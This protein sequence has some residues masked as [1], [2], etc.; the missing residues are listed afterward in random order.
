MKGLDK[1]RVATLL[2]IIAMMLI[3][4]TYGYRLQLGIQGITFE[5]NTRR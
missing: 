1:N 5:S 4:A 3:A 2:A